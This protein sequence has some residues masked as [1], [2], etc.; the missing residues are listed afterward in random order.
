MKFQQL[1]PM[2]W[3]NELEGTIEFYTKL[4]GFE[5]DEYNVDWGWCNLRKDGAAIMFAKPND[6]E[7]FDKPYA[8]GSFY[9]YVE[10]VD[11]LWQALKDST[12]VFYA[13]DNFEHG[14]REFAIR[15]NNGYVLQF[16]REL[17]EGETITLE[18]V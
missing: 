14:M 16:G 12:T 1:T 2:L 18:I 5:L 13:I 15:D 8:T 3:T 10:E 4:L 11:D 7:P 9:I 17:K 6:H